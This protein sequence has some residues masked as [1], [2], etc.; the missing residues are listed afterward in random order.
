MK[1]FLACALLCL[2]LSAV[3]NANGKSKSLKPHKRDIHLIEA[4]TQ[5]TLPGRRE[6][7]PETSLNFIIE[8]KAKTYPETFFWR[9]EGGW[10]SCRMLKAHR[11]LQG[12]GSKPIMGSGYSVEFAAGDN[13]HKGDTLMLTPVAGGKFPIPAEIPTT[14]RNTLYYTTAGSGWRPFPVDSISKKRDIV[15]P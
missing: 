1:T 11:I 7:P 8:W 2:I 10:L 4:Y 9:G 15:A 5:K 3:I 13:I 14:S 12:A 6:S